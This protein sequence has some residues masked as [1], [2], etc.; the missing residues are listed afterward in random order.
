[1][2]DNQLARAGALHF[3]DG[4]KTYKVAAMVRHGGKHI[5]TECMT[6]NLPDA[7][8][9]FAQWLLTQGLSVEALCELDISEVA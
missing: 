2:S 9:Y 4:M 6:F 5:E 3:N 8:A 7:Y 1:M